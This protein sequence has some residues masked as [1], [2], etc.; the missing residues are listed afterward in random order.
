MTIDQLEMIEAIVITGSFQSAAKKLHKSQPSLSVGIKKIE[1]LYGIEI[2]SREKYRPELTEKGEL[3]YNLAKNTLRSYRG[4]DRLGRE[5]GHGR[6]S[7][8]RFTIDPLINIE[9]LKII[10]NNVS[11]DLELTPLHFQ[12]AIFEEPINK[13]LNNEC[14]FSIGHYKNLKN[15]NIQTKLFCKVELQAAISKE[16]IGSKKVTL[17]LLNNFPNIVVKTGNAHLDI[18]NNEIINRWYVTNHARKEEMILNGLGWGKIAKTTINDQQDKLVKIGTNIIS[19]QTL[20]I[21][22]MRN[23]LMPMGP[24]AK[25]I[26]SSI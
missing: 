17:E 19:S 10:L 7:Q 3:F 9:R 12:E 6:E 26:W 23:K 13:L 4:L 20:E 8:I 11:E 16:L 14:D 25:K 24:I 1:E 15:S 2:F 21:H 22:F 18:S 5:L